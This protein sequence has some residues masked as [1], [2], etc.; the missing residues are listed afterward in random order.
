MKKITENLAGVCGVYKIINLING[1]IY[2]GSS[3]SLRNRLWEHRAKLRHN[4]HHNDHLQNAWNKYREDNFDYCIL[5]TCSEEQQYDREQFYINS[6]HPEYNIAEEVILPSYSEE[7]RKKHSET[8]KRMYK[9]GTLMPNGRR[10]IYM[11]DLQGNFIRKFD[12]E[13]EAS[14]ELGIYRTQIEK[15]LSGENKRCRN[16][17]FKYDYYPSIEPYKKAPKDNSCLWKTI[18]VYNEQE[19]YFFKNA[20]ECCSHF[21]VH[22]VYI[23]DAIKHHRHFLRKYTIEYTTAR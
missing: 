8:K 2:I 10:T 13:R 7:S 18:R 6:F 1:K 15:N 11:Y 14:K 22:L 19:E 21:N 17:I 4:K 23:R 16:Y 20:Q 9:E 3:K 5:E 12:S